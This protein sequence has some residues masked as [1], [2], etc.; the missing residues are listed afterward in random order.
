MKIH[1]DGRYLCTMHISRF[2]PGG[3]LKKREQDIQTSTDCVVQ[4][5][6][7]LRFRRYTSLM[8]TEIPSRLRSSLQ[9]ITEEK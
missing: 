2:V 6:F 1:V 4:S 7:G 3:R 9:E 5:M 8:S